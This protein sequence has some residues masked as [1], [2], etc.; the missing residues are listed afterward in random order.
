[1]D[2]PTTTNRG[3]TVST[4]LNHTSY[5]RAQRTNDVLIV[6]SFALWAM[7]IGFLPVVAFRLLGA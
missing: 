4:N 7:L 1:M 6:S 3:D 2:V 5:E